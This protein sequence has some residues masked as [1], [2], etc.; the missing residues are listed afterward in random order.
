MFKPLAAAASVLAG[1]CLVAPVALSQAFESTGLG[2]IDP[3]GVGT[4][5]RADGALPVTLWDGSRAEDL[6]PLLARI[7]ARNVTPVTRDL[8]T[9]MLL[10]PARSPEGDADALLA[11]R[12]RLVWEL[13]EIEAYAEL[14]GRLP[15]MGDGELRSASTAQTEQEFAR[16]NLASACSAVRSASQNDAY[17]LQARAT[18]FALERNFSSADLAI[19]LSQEFDADNQWLIRAINALRTLPEDPEE[20]AEADLPPASFETGQAI[21]ISLDA[22]FPY[23]ARD[24]RLMNPGFAR[25]VA[26]R[27]DVSRALR[28][29]AAK[30]A[31][32]AGLMTADELRNAYRLEPVP[33]ADIPE[34]E[35]TEEDAA[36]SDDAEAAVEDDEEAEAE[37]NTV[38]APV[39]PLDEA[40]Q[41]AADPD[42]EAEEV[43]QAMRRALMLAQSSQSRFALTAGVLAPDLAKMDDVTA[44]GEN[45]ELFALAGFAAGDPQLS[46]K[47][48]EAPDIEGGPDEDPYLQAWLNA[49]RVVTGA[50]SSAESVRVASANLADR[51]SDETELSSVR[52][53]QYLLIFGDTLSADANGFIAGDAGD[54]LND[55]TAIA[56]KDQFLIASGLNGEGAGEGL[57]RLISVLGNEP[58]KLRSAD[59]AFALSALMANGFENE[60]RAIALEN[61][62]YQKPVK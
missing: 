55:G 17:S 47:F 26:L 19:E 13:G 50:D 5:S 11:Q 1:A 49:L 20:R 60:A 59:L 36:Q 24:I 28:I 35:T 29:E 48:Q 30:R 34:S 46:A 32:F 14:A 15:E 18:C 37:E 62:A 58:E 25:V 31:A 8:L 52:M 57:L 9:R 27:K 41:L 22:G 2:E 7:N 53:M 33:E 44:L 23:E 6:E 43:V 3:W 51:S 21:A 16:G 40:L 10:S 45:A 54:R 61:L 4:L 56:P 39:D 12:L 38:N 42:A